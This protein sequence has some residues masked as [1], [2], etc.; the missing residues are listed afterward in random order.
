MAINALYATQKLLNGIS[1]LVSFFVTAFACEANDSRDT[2]ISIRIRIILDGDIP[3]VPTTVLPKDLTIKT[4]KRR[5]AQDMI[6]VNRESL[7]IKDVVVA[8]RIPQREGTIVSEPS[9]HSIAVRDFRPSAPLI[10]TN[11]L[12]EVFF[13]NSSNFQLRKLL[14]S[15]GKEIQTRA[16]YSGGE[17]IVSFLASD[18]AIGGN[19]MAFETNPFSKVYVVVWPDGIAACSDSDGLVELSGI[20]KG[21]TFEMELFHRL[22][23]GERIRRYD[24]SEPLYVT[25]ERR[26]GIREQHNQLEEFEL[27][28]KPDQFS[29]YHIGHR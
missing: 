25:Q 23:K 19:S 1:L 17:K 3:S 27:K 2:T 24:C 8:I 28:I 5:V 12:D 9:S 29:F 26:I 18:I 7:G 6:E 21:E 15:N 16:V 10:I 14:D 22:A 4:G 20:P 13:V 11:E